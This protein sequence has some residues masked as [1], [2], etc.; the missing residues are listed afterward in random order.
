MKPCPFYLTPAWIGTDTR[1]AESSFGLPWE[2]L[3]VL[4]LGEAEL[5]VLA[6]PVQ[7]QP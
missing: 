2:P 6:E 1:R 5:R 4:V 3:R 7:N